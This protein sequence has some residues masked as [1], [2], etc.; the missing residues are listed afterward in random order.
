MMISDL[1]HMESASEIEVNG[2]NSTYTSIEVSAYGSKANVNGVATAFG[3][4]TGANV[5]IGTRAAKG[6]RY[7][8]SAGTGAATAYSVTV[9]GKN[10]GVST[11]VSTGVATDVK[12]F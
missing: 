12:I 11:S 5:L 2:G 9:N 3:Q 10:S 1:Q 7:E 6:Y 8:L 4:N